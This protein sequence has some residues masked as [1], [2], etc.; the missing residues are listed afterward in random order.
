V[1]TKVTEWCWEH[2]Q[3]TGTD[4]LVL[5]AIGDQ[6]SHEGLNAYPSYATLAHRCRVS[7]KTVQRSVQKLEALGEL[8]VD[9]RAGP[10]REG[11]TNQ[12]PNIYS[13]PAFR[14]SAGHE[15]RQDVHSFKEDATSGTEDATS[16]T[17]RGDRSARRGDTAVT[18]DPSLDSSL[19]DPS[20]DPTAARPKSPAV[21][22]GTRIPDPFVV[23]PEMVAWARESVPTVDGARETA[24][25]V[26]HFTAK[27]GRDAVKLDWL[28]TWRNWMRTAEERLPQHR[29]GNG[30][31]PPKPPASDVAA[32]QVDTAFEGM[33]GSNDQL[34][35]PE[36]LLL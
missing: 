35:L 33:F 26:D 13:F 28:A 18:S 29:N 31:R 30:H 6:A 7:I 22:R 8:A 14:I 21:S 20:V 32:A 11:R 17:G 3:A 16:G 9:R 27:V 36:E 1:S 34:A 10:A 12:R 19:F 2:S 23:T 24:K 15:T 4:R 25:F 5:I